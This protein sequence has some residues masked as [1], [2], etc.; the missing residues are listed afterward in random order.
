MK[1]IATL[2]CAAVALLMA[3]CAQKE[4]AP[5][6][7]TGAQLGD[8]FETSINIRYVSQDSIYKYYVF[9]QTTTLE[10]QQLY[11]DLESYRNQLGNQLQAQAN[12][13][14]Q[15]AQ[16]NQYLS[17][18]TY[19]NDV[20][21]LNSK[22]SNFENLI[23]QRAAQVDAQAQLKQQALEDSINNF[24]VQFNKSRQ[25]DAILE[26]KFNLYLNPALDITQ[27]VIEGLNARYQMPAPAASK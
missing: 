23:A 3:S 17:Q 21:A 2:I 26:R 12:Q 22:Q 8:P 1:K 6:S 4:A 5:A 16:N 25:Y 14:Q 18:A 11:I 9:A 24:I 19:E 13:I 27:D 20:K 10:I 7:S 15:K